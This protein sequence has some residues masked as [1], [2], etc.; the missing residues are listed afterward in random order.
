[1]VTYTTAVICAI[2]ISSVLVFLI[3]IRFKLLNFK[4]LL[5]GT[6]ASLI[7]AIALPVIFKIISA[8][9]SG[10]TEFSTLLTIMIIS[11]AIYLILAFILSLI[12]SHIIQVTGVKRGT[13]KSEMTEA[14][15]AAADLIMAAEIE[16]AE[17][18]SKAAT[19]TAVSTE[20]SSEIEDSAGSL[21]YLE[22]IYDNMIQDHNKEAANNVEYAHEAENNLEKS[23][24]STENID[25]MGIESE[26]QESENLTIEDCIEEAFRLKEQD[27]G[28]GA[29][30]YYMYALDK[31]PLKELA[32]WIVLDIC[33][34]YKTL[35]QKELAYD[36]LNSYHDIF[37]DIMDDSVKKE[38]EYNLSSV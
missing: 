32:F 35:G 18:D 5:S 22:Q 11:I 33:V 36:I 30:L 7:S 19:E 27:D 16:T 21:N 4:I 10:A 2:V 14:V 37:R 9:K 1:M 20:I 15:P 23:V 31:K 6:L 38:I 25:K 28:E 3:S 26:E 24:D 29:I 17:S 8:N 13:S 34:I 12:I